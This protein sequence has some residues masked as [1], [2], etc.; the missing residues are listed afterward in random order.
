MK[1]GVGDSVSDISNGLDIVAVIYHK[2]SADT[3]V[4]VFLE[5]FF[6]IEVHNRQ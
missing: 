3:Q 6:S 4:F 1:Y 2:L 5:L